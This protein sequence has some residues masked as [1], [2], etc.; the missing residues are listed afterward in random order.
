MI[1]LL[2][3]FTVGILILVGLFRA[4]MQADTSIF[5][6]YVGEIKYP[7]TICGILGCLLVIFAR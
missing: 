6:P 5:I 4:D 7:I 2:L 3:T 1:E